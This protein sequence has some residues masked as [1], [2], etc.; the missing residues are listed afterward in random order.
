MLK[1]GSTA[2]EA[3]LRTKR[4][5]YS[6]LSTQIQDH[7]ANIPTPKLPALIKKKIF[8][9]PMKISFHCSA[10]LWDVLLSNR[11]WNTSALLSLSVTPSRARRQRM[12]RTPSLGLTPHHENILNHSRSQP[13]ISLAQSVPM[14]FFWSPCLSL[15]SQSPIPT[16]FNLQQMDVIKISLLTTVLHAKTKIC[17]WEHILPWD[18]D[19]LIKTSNYVLIFKYL[20][21]KIMYW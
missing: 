3:N 11:M 14:H 16:Y 17:I 18:Q 5:K 4:M 13:L 2:H 20:W 1:V 21:K 7:A 12:V 10:R 6:R 8:R 9:N 19:M 15:A